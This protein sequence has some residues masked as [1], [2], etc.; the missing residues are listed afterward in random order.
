MP[1]GAD[2]MIGNPL[3]YLGED[4]EVG[5]TLAPPLPSLKA[6]RALQRV[7]QGVGH[8]VRLLQSAERLLAA[9][10]GAGC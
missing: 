4:V 9:L 8:K 1:L 3:A 5:Q 7:A 6:D 2:M 10:L